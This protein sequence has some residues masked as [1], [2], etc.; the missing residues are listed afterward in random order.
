MKLTFLLFA[1]AL[2]P[3]AW[4][5]LRFHL[6]PARDGRPV[7]FL[8]I[9]SVVAGSPAEQAGLRKQDLIVEL[10]GKPIAFGTSLEALKFFSNLRVGQK[11]RA[12]VVRNQEKRE[13]VMTAIALPDHAR[14]AWD[15]NVTR[16][17]APKS[18]R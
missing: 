7:A 11:L 6:E 18:P 15:A 16:A 2:T 17:T 3:Q 13:I 12:N 10:D 9:D 14:P 5:G 4:L 8:F 1:V